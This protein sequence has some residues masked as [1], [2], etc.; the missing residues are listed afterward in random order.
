MVFSSAGRATLTPSVPSLRRSVPAASHA[1]QVANR[2][3]RQHVRTDGA[4][5]QGFISVKPQQENWAERWGKRGGRGNGW[6]GEGERSVTINTTD[7]GDK[8]QC[9]QTLT[10]ALNAWSER[11]RGRRWRRGWS[12]R[13]RVDEIET[14]SSWRE[15]GRLQQ[16]ICVSFT[17]V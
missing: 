15:E 6:G 13:K 3:F 11:Q 14:Q 17:C 12:G 9:Y 7:E 4:F 16:T 10:A 8:G 2:C 1:P 5:T